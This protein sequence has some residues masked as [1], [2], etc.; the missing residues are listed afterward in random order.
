MEDKIPQS[1]KVQWLNSTLKFV[2]NDNQMVMEYPQMPIAQ[3]E[4]LHNLIWQRQNNVGLGFKSLYAPLWEAMS[5]YSVK[6]QFEVSATKAASGELGQLR[7]QKKPKT[8]NEECDK[9]PLESNIQE[10][11]KSTH[12]VCAEPIIQ[13]QNKSTNQECAKVVENKDIEMVKIKPKKPTKG[14]KY[15]VH[16]R[17]IIDSIAPAFFKTTFQKILDFIND[18]AS[19][20]FIFSDL[21]PN[22]AKFLEN[23]LGIYNRR[24]YF[25]VFFSPHCN[26]LLNKICI[27]F[28]EFDKNSKLYI[29]VGKT[30]T[31]TCKRE[32]IFC[33]VPRYTRNTYSKAKLSKNPNG[34]LSSEN[35]TDSSSCKFLKALIKTDSSTNCDHNTSN[36]ISNSDSCTIDNT[37]TETDDEFQFNARDKENVKNMILNNVNLKD[38]QN[39]ALVNSEKSCEIN[40]INNKSKM[41]SVVQVREIFEFEA[42]STNN[43]DLHNRNELVNKRKCPKTIDLRSSNE[44]NETNNIFIKAI[45]KIEK[46]EV[47][48]KVLPESKEKKKVVDNSNINNLFK[49]IKE[50]K[51]TVNN[52][53]EMDIIDDIR[54]KMRS[55]YLT[56]NNTKKTPQIPKPAIPFAKAAESTD[57]NKVIDKSTDA[58]LIQGCR[59]RKL[60]EAMSTPLESDKGLRMMRLMGWEGGALG[61]RGEGIVEPIIPALHIKPGAGLGHIPEKP[62]PKQDKLSNRL[63]LLDAILNLITKDVNASIISYNS[64]ITIKER[65]CFNEIINLVNMKKPLNLVNKFEVGFCQ[66]IRE[67]MAHAQFK[68]GLV[69]DSNRKLIL[70]KILSK[71]IKGKTSKKEKKKTTVITIPDCNTESTNIIELPTEKTQFTI[72][73]LTKVL[74]FQKEKRNL[75]LNIHFDSILTTIHKKVLEEL[76]SSVNSKVM[77]TKKQ[78]SYKNLVVELYYQSLDDS[79]FD[80][81]F[82][83]DLKSFTIRKVKQN[84]GTNAANKWKKAAETPTAV[85][86]KNNLSNISWTERDQ[87]AL[88][89]NN[90]YGSK[91]VNLNTGQSEVPSNCSR[92]KENKPYILLVQQTN[93]K[94]HKNIATFVTTKIDSETEFLPYLKC[95][96][97][98]DGYAVYSCYEKRSYLWLKNLLTDYQVVDYRGMDELYVL[99]VE[100]N[101]NIECKKVLSLLELYN[102]GLNCSDWDILYFNFFYDSSEFLVQLDFN[103]FEY[104]RNNNF[105]LSAGVDDVKFTINIE[106]YGNDLF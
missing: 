93:N 81:T 61:L 6:Y 90:N 97:V 5:I 2:K 60:L 65:R 78:V 37:D 4:Y 64:D 101:V 47:K 55:V 56:D 76:C 42:K 38:E 87:S 91:E 85:E 98:Q 23:F 70:N 28:K 92:V 9:P 31:K 75:V 10:M 73:I 63:Q 86:T 89:T 106:Y 26:D 77:M 67:N 34:Q 18:E 36:Y 30:D 20:S 105:M 102:P 58:N 11:Q 94:C 32:I 69:H 29:Y 74:E 103:S 96:G 71:E 27:S 17:N 40:E 52:K 7:I 39:T 62:T 1:F 15:Y 82:G 80:I 25:G 104:V 83:I 41:K 33:K 68:L 50:T 53:K 95:H 3:V 46:K 51:I 13:Q 84:P 19:A 57:N 44:T 88:D 66:K 8:T 54:E 79:F 14:Q 99:K 72:L 45:D 35:E 43:I 49:N 12:P 100:I 21:A 16:A 59:K 48:E 22:E 24:T